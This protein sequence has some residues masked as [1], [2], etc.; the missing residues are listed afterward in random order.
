[1]S[2]G[3]LYLC[4]VRP[5]PEGGSVT[6]EKKLSVHH[7]GEADGLPGTYRIKIMSDLQPNPTVIG[8]MEAIAEGCEGIFAVLAAADFE[9][10]VV[11]VLGTSVNPNRTTE[12][13]IRKVN[14]WLHELSEREIEELKRLTLRDETYDVY[15]R[16]S[17][18]TS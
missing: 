2:I 15:D 9:S 13:W 3:V 6:Q 18:G 7:A 8:Y 1:M 14:A 17:V 10:N 12:A 16:F 4:P 5:F 11:L